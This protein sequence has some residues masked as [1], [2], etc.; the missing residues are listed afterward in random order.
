MATDRDFSPEDWQHIEAAPLM[1][2]LAI[3][4]GD[5]SSKKGIADEAEATGDAIKAGAS[6]SSEI[7]RTLAAR[8][9]RGERPMMPKI[10]KHPASA[11]NALVDAC[12]AAADRVAA[13]APGE[14]SAYARFL[15]EIARAS[16]EASREGGFLGVG[17]TKVS[18]GEQLALANLALSLGLPTQPEPR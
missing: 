1:A 17:I 18:K 14:A 6:S 11:Q 10:P 7:V 9:T 2:G 12:K 8:F 4:Y 16:A 3:T 15:V 13:K 5:L